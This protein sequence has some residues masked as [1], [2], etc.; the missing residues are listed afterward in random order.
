VLGCTC[1]RLSTHELGKVHAVG[2]RPRVV[3]SFVSFDLIYEG[4]RDGRATCRA[5]AREWGRT[6]RAWTLLVQAHVQTSTTC[7]HGCIQHAHREQ[8]DGLDPETETAIEA[9]ARVRTPE[10]APPVGAWARHVGALCARSPLAKAGGTDGAC[11]KRAGRD[12]QAQGDVRL[13]A[14]LARLPRTPLWDARVD[15]GGLDHREGADRA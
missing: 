4:S 6:P 8:G 11:H 10:V 2:C 14:L 1:W 13:G 5:A 12:P 7:S 15:C 9:S 3:I